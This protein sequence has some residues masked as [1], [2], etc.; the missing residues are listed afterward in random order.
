MHSGQNCGVSYMYYTWRA[1]DSYVA[2]VIVVVVVVV[3]VPF[4]GS[5]PCCQLAPK[6]G[7]PFRHRL[8]DASPRPLQGGLDLCRRRTNMPTGQQ[9]HFTLAWQT[10][11]LSPCTHDAAI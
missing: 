3:A 10:I 2:V 11:L 4:R 1:L 7:Y 9:V 5:V 8:A 6:T